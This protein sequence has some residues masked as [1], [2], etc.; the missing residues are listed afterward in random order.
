MEEQTLT[1][2]NHEE[3]LTTY[4]Q[5]RKFADVTLQSDG[6][7]VCCCH[8]AVLAA[9]STHLESLFSE[10]KESPR[11]TLDIDSYLSGVSQSDL[12]KIIDF[13]YG[14]QTLPSP[15]LFESARALGILRLMKLIETCDPKESI[16]DSDHATT[17]S[18]ALRRFCCDRKFTDVTVRHENVCL[19]SCHR[20]VLAAYS[21]YFET[22][23]EADEAAPFVYLDI[24][25]T[26]DGISTTDLQNVIDFMY[27]GVDTNPSDILLFED[28][29]S[30]ETALVE[31][32]QVNLYDEYVSGPRRRRNLLGTFRSQMKIK[33]RFDRVKR[34]RSPVDPEAEDFSATMFIED[35]QLTGSIDDPVVN[36]VDSDFESVTLSL[37]APVNKR[38]YPASTDEF[39]Y[40]LP[41]YVNPADVTV[42]LLVGDQQLLMEKP[43]KCTY[44]DHRTKEKSA[45]EKHIRC[46]HTLETPYKCDYCSQA[47]K[48]QSNLVRHIRAH[49]GEKPYV[50]K[51][52]GTPYA[53]KKNMDAHI[54][55]QHL[56][57]KPFQC[58]SE[59]CSAK[60]WRQD[61]FNYHCRRQHGLE[62]HVF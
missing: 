47:F 50:C 62:P 58:P 49:T 1:A 36:D 34:F 30:E 40:G 20:L 53:D 14:G 15:T 33:K 2:F 29:G 16:V 38:R 11:I 54:F 5:H 21:E 7:V 22:A 48:V 26:N 6:K 51:K 57:M 42:P 18:A 55:R 59:G 19:V 27:T 31:D 43:F 37:T 28:I 61:R 23:L 32:P 41:A 10:T 8:K 60:F 35:P 9:F 17:I 52:C 39:G 3:S 44:C 45:L 24:N 56:K 46:I 4:L 13:M 12:I 25:G